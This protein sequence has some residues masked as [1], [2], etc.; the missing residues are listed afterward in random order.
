MINV[1]L[2]YWVEAEQYGEI[3]D[4]CIENFDKKNE[5]VTWSLL[6]NN[7]IGGEIYFQHETD[8]VAFKLRWL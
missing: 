2:H 5:R 1:D 6:A 4:W 7:D 8:A 3:R